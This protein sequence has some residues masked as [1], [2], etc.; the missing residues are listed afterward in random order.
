M[1]QLG[2]NKVTAD[3]M[4][5]RFSWQLGQHR[6][7]QWESVMSE[8][9]GSQLASGMSTLWQS[10]VYFYIPIQDL[11]AHAITDKD[12]VLS[13]VLP[14]HL[15]RQFFSS[16]EKK[17]WTIKSSS[18]MSGLFFLSLNTYRIHSIR[19]VPEVNK[20]NMQLRLI[21]KPPGY[22]KNWWPRS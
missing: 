16:S 7:E 22:D 11:Q 4:R 3:K 2:I 5:L 15:W 21:S 6:A 20:L 12:R 10:E 14:H 19:K 17:G 1:P 13:S 9:G 8:R 18:G